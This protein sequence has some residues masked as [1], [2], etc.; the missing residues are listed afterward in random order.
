M[1]RHNDLINR[2]KAL[3]AIVTK[4]TRQYRATVRALAPDSDLKGSEMQ[5]TPQLLTGM[6]LH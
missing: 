3:Y 1:Y 2:T 6:F 4:D 5:S